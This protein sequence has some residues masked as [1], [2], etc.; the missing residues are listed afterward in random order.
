M[1]DFNTT[2][3]EEV[4]VEFLEDRELSNLIFHTCF[5]SKENPSMTDLVITN[6]PK[7]FQNAIDISTG[8]SDFQK[9]ILTTMKT[10][11]P[12]AA[13][14]T[15]TYRDMKKLDK[16]AF[17]FDLKEKLQQVDTA[18]YESFEEIFENV[19]DTHAPKKTKVLR[20]NDKPFVTKAM[21]KAIMKRSELSTKYQSQPT[22]ENQK[23]FKKQKFL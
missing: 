7:S 17:K 1:G 20:A 10:T 12:K 14:K 3:S 11:F 19:L 18:N 22:E 6:K 16:T 8:L 9:M 13:I 15:I 21:R 5:M 2:P 23:A 4:I